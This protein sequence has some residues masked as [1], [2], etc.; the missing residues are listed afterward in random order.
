[1][2]VKM[3]GNGAMDNI[4]PYFLFSHFLPSHRKII[5]QYTRLQPSVKSSGRYSIV[6]LS[7]SFM[8]LVLRVNATFRIWVLS[9][10]ELRNSLGEDKVMKL[11][12]IRQ[13]MKATDGIEIDPFSEDEEETNPT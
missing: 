3:H 13:I 12:Y 7:S 10:S 8:H 2:F 5:I 9:H 1:V 11:T 6:K 4:L